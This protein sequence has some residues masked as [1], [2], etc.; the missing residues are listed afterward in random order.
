MSSATNAIDAANTA[1]IA[2][3][4]VTKNMMS[5]CSKSGK[6]RATRKTP[7]VTIVAEWIK[8]DTEVGPSIASGNQECRG[9]CADLPMAPNKKPSAIHDATETAITPPAMAPYISWISSHEGLF[10]YR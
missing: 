3:T 7:A 2:P 1:V 6:N 10:E 5:L 8:A 9:N 4:N